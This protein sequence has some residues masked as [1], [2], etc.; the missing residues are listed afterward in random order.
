MPHRFVFD[1][2]LKLQKEVKTFFFFK[3]LSD[4]KSWRSS[5]TAAKFG[6]ELLGKVSWLRSGSAAVDQ[7]ACK[8]IQE[9]THA[10]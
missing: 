7:Q 8:S 3:K 2:L 5:K 1:L 10:G 6:S 4:K 9:S